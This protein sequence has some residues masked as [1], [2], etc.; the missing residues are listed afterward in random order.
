[1][2]RRPIHAQVSFILGT[3]GDVRLQSGFRVFSSALIEARGRTV[4]ELIVDAAQTGRIFKRL[5]HITPHRVID[6]LQ[7]W[8]N[9][10]MA[11][12]TIF[13]R[14]SHLNWLF[15]SLQQSKILISKEVLNFLKFDGDTDLPLKRQNVTNEEILDAIS[16][17]SGM[18]KFVGIQ[19]KLIYQVGLTVSE[20]LC[21]RPGYIAEDGVLELSRDGTP[22]AIT[23]V[24]S[25]SSLQ[26]QVIDEAFDLMK[27]NGLSNLRW[28]EFTLDAW[29]YHFYFISKKCGFSHTGL[30]IT[31]SRLSKILPHNNR[32]KKCL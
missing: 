18:D 30:G 9:K 6:V 24:T 8:A 2:Q 15:L 32:L 31:P 5:D 23:F 3:F 11:K 21:F 20:A 14:I 25:I 26:K 10:G 13:T 22:K 28:P 19:L 4:Y 16:A 1:M 7:L 12:E 29:R 27:R 17:A